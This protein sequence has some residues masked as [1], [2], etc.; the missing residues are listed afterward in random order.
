[1]SNL[2][3]ALDLESKKDAFA[4]VNQI[5]PQN[6]ALKVGSQMFTRYGPSFVEA[7]SRLGF[8][9]FLDLKFHDIPNTVAKACQACAALNVWML[10][11]HASGGL[12]MMRAAKKALATFPKP[13]LLMAVTVLTSMQAT[14]LSSIGLS[15]DLDAQVSR[16]AALAYEAELDGVVCSA[17]EVP[18]IKTLTKTKPFLTL[19]PGIR[20]ASET[21]H[22][23]V[24][25]V[26][27]TEALR[28][29]SDYIVVG[30][31][32]TT[33]KDPAAVVAEILKETASCIR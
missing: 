32:I 33:A 31:S 10:T 23:Q 29:G 5:D 8:K 17:F 13:P 24:R 16:L 18:L 11:L 27:P 4:L 20:L 22:D 1:M 15:E 12:A 25:V 14:D 30:R 28:L 19:T 9:I 6:C 2:I 26:S 3:I 21:A 7:L